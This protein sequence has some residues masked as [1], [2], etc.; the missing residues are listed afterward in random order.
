VKLTNIGNKSLTSLG[1]AVTG[2]NAADFAI[3]SNSCRA[4]EKEDASCI[5]SII[6]TPG[7][8]G[9]RSAALS[10]TDN[11]YNSPQTVALTGTGQ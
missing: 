4:T 9:L 1:V 11:A 2:A 3:S 6:F 10:F 5:V 8:T 7:A